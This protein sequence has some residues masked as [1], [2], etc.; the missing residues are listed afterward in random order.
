MQT[1]TIAPTDDADPAAKAGRG[2]P[3]AEG[4]YAQAGER[5]G[6]LL[7]RINQARYMAPYADPKCAAR[8]ARYALL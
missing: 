3:K 8:A 1:Q 5:R 4:L 7:R 6:M 2:A